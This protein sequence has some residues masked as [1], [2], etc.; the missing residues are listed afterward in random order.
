MSILIAALL[1]MLLSSLVLNSIDKK[2]QRK[3]LERASY[4]RRLSEAGYYA[5]KSGKNFNS[6]PYPRFTNEYNNWARGHN[7]YR[8]EKL[9]KGKKT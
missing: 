3:S 8:Y 6:N 4:R 2:I 7:Q 9:M 1:G 5:A